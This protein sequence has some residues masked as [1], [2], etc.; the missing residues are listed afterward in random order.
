MQNLK[1]NNPFIRLLIVFIIFNSVFFTSCRKDS[2]S[3]IPPEAINGVLN[4]HNWDLEKDGPV[5]LKGEWDFYWNKQLKPE[6]FTKINSPVKTGLMRFPGVWNGY[7]IN[8]EKLSGD[9]FA[10]YRLKIM[11]ND[12]MGALAFKLLDMGTTYSLYVNGEKI[13]YAGVTGKTSETTAPMYFPKISNFISES[14]QIEIILHISNFHHRLGGPWEVIR[15]GRERDIREIRE[16]SLIFDIFLFGGILIMGIYHL[17]LF[18]LRKKDRSPL[19]FGFFCILIALRLITTGEK[20]LI[21]LFP[22]IGWELL[23]KLEYLSFYLGVPIFAMFIYSLF[24]KEFSKPVLRVIQFL[25]I[26]FSGL[27]IFAPVKIYS[28]SVQLY[29]ILTLISCVYAIYVLTLS[30]SRKREGA[31][32]F[33]CGFIILSLTVIH[34]ILFIHMITQI[35]YLTPFGYLAPF[36]LLTFIFFQAFL[37][38]N[39]YAKSFIIIEK[40]SNELKDT[41]AANEYEIAER[42]KAELSLIKFR[43]EL[44][45]LVAERT[46]ALTDTNRQLQEEIT[47]HKQ[48]EKE[49]HESRELFHSFMKNLPALAFMKDSNGRYIYFNEACKIFYNVDP[50]DRIG[51]TDDEL[52]PE[53]VA[54]Q[55]KKNDRQVMLERQVISTVETVTVQDKIQHHLITKFPIIRN[56]TSPILAGIAFDIT[57]KKQTEKDKKELESQLQRAQKMEALGLLAGGVAHDLNNVLS[58]IVGYPDLLLMDLPEDS[59]LKEPIQAIQNSGIK[60][61]EIVQDMLTIS[62]RG[63]ANVNILNI[64]DI[65]EDYLKSAEY[66]KLRFH[67][68][69]IHLETNCS[70]DLLNIKGS[71]I[72]LKK[73]VMNLVSNAAESNPRD[74]SIIIKTENKY[75]DKPIKGYDNIQ[76]GEFAVLQITDKGTGIAPDDLKHIFEPFFTK[77]VMGRSG[78]GLGM[79][80][81]WGTVQDHKGYIHIESTEGKGSTFKLYFPVTREDLV[82]KKDMVPI[83]KFRGSGESI[84][85]VDDVKEQREIASVFLTNLGYAV[86]TVA[87]GEKAVEYIKNNAVDLLVLDMIM[88]P[89]I[90]GLDTYKKII[91]LNPEQKAIIASGFSET[92]RVKEAQ[93]L[94]A[95]EY[96]NKPYNLEKIGLAVK[97]ELNK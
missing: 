53:D 25:G 75:V 78:T 74:G 28:H 79:A 14:N 11:M 18:S 93:N 23:V 8:G 67:H 41:I 72:H 80:V 16:K 70:P 17:I 51:K 15:F 2:K 22:G 48:S 19:Y 7:L 1:T 46:A 87:S 82:P 59:S 86:T 30:F 40:Q 31:L 52:W 91:K 13:S 42:K 33:L 54:E 66:E 77:K 63:V 71:S 88:D 27:V 39:R 83:E 21:M 20:H 64:N 9:G 61:A 96:V 76:E 50:A 94:G 68:P 60:A 58:A 10:T 36:G 26:S 5:D 47:E 29:Q 73:T 12:Q 55:L 62:R 45:G 44:K 34:D 4:L 49:L 3:K 24:H 85:V 65:I 38:S 92:D 43:D 97:R 95:G 90:D 69:G 84:L 35:R 57:E 89:G 6:D 56:E 37:L 81:V 32:L